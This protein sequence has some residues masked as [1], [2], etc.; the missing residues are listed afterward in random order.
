MYFVIRGA[1]V[2]NSYFYGLDLL[3]VECYAGKALQFIV[4]RALN[5]VWI[6]PLTFAIILIH[7]KSLLAHGIVMR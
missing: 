5:R 2:G 3:L 6:F 4:L 1:G 7:T